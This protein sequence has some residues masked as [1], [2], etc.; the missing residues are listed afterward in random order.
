MSL[1]EDVNTETEARINGIR[2]LL[3]KAESVIEC[4]FTSQIGFHHTAD[5]FS[6][7]IMAQ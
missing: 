1:L 3:L 7:E 5:F 6:R 4:D 2:I